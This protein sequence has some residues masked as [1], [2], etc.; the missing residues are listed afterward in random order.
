MW[1]SLWPRR[2]SLLFPPFA[3]RFCEPQDGRSSSA[4]RS[5]P[6]TSSSYRLIPA[7]PGR[8]KRPSEWRRP[9][10]HP[11][12]APLR[13]CER[14][15]DS[16]TELAGV[17]DVV[18]ILRTDAGTLGEGQVLPPWC[19]QH[20]FRSI[21]FV[22][23]RDH[24]RRVRRVLDRV[25]KGHPTRVTVQPARYSSFDLDRWWETRGGVRT[26]IIELQKLLFQAVLDP[27]LF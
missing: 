4:S 3:S 17:T 1:W 12:G 10:V 8:S 2:A 5:R 23:A 13:G 22:A 18:Q 14:K 26:E 7:A 20:L 19:D 27:M 11:P 9:R 16:P 15:A 25:M 24:S 21:V 6:L